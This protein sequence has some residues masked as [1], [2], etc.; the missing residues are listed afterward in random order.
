MFHK[1]SRPQA[2]VFGAAS[3][4]NLS[5]AGQQPSYLRR[6][7]EESIA[8][9]FARVGSYLYGAMERQSVQ[10]PDGVAARQLEFADFPA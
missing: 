7:S 10:P 6:T 5:G 1:L 4:L 8:R 9:D 3:I 2:F